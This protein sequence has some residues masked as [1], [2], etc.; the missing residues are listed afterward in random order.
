MSLR[1][2]PNVL[3]LDYFEWMRACVVVVL[4]DNPHEAP[5]RECRE[6]PDAVTQ[7]C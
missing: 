3:H 1:H 6:A 5:M 2:Y 7:V 4:I